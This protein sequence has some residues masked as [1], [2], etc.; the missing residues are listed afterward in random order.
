MVNYD[1]DPTKTLYEALIEADIEVRNHYSDLLCPV[2]AISKDLI[3]RHQ[4]Y[5]TMFRNNDTGTMW[6]DVPMAYDPYWAEHL[7]K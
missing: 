3:Q 5:A 4:K 7:G 6:Y 2:N 1:Y